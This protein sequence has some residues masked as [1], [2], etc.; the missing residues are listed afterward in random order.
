MKFLI[1]ALGS[2]ETAHG[3][4][5]AK[6]L[7][8]K[9]HQVSMALLQEGSL[10]FC[11][12]SP[13]I[14]VAIATTPEALQALAKS[15]K[16]DAILLCN[17]KSFNDTS[18]AE[19]S[20]WDGIPTFGV[21]SNWLFD[22]VG[23]H[24]YIQWLDGYFIVL[25]EPLFKLGSKEHGG[26]FSLPTERVSQMMPVGF[27]PSYQKLDELTR[28]QVRQKLGIEA[29]E[30]LIFCYISGYAAR[31]RAFILD[32][33][34]QA[35]RRLRSQGQS[36]KILAI[37]NLDLIE[38]LSLYETDWLLW[39]KQ[40]TIEDFYTLLAS[41]DLVFQHQGHGTLSQAIAAQI[42]VI[43][44]I[45]VRPDIPYPLIPMAENMTFQRAGLCHLLY[46]HSPLE[47][48]QNA[49]ETLLY[50]QAKICEMQCR[51]REHSSRG[52]PHLYTLLMEQ[53]LGLSSSQ[54]AIT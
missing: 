28:R 5:I 13:D 15:I 37:G 1:F 12:P 46:S 26:H 39:R 10:H 41:A 17:S 32:N 49:I 52:E 35:V 44:N 22:S 38:N 54:V 2:G 40:A 23:P 45:E 47:D 21:D 25:P 51:Q 36:I 24:R 8:E 11:T 4:A 14:S 53:L 7:V 20:P 48:V 42:P 43:V 31:V 16:P 19:V 34:F 6:H 33:L 9:K 50:D 30:Q 29:H 18:F 3:Y 27:I